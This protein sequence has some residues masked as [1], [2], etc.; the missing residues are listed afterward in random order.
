M[1]DTPLPVRNGIPKPRSTTAAVGQGARSGWPFAIGATALVIGALIYVTDR[2]PSRAVWMPAFAA[3]PGPA[4]FGGAGGWLPSFVHPLSFSLMC[5]AVSRPRAR[6]A[7]AICAFW[8]LLNA[9]FEC[10]QHP[11]VA[12]SIAAWLTNVAGGFAP[13]RVLGQYFVRGTFDLGD[14]IACI[15]GAIVA[16]ALLNAFHTPRR[17]LA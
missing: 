5:A 3:W 15:A 4:W 13:A 8:G 16:A 6:P 1:E 10:G 12:M 17:E 2:D 9:V 14:L 7:Y 11:L